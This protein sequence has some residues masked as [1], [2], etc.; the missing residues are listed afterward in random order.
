MSTQQIE[1]TYGETV[2]MQ[3]DGAQASAPIL[4]DG[5]STGYQTA[6]A[7][8]RTE[9]AVRL[10]CAKMWGPIYAT[11]EDAEAAG[12]TLGV[13]QIV[14]WDDVEYSTLDAE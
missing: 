13:D 6:D 12:R 2:V 3:W 4:V 14:I 8:H 10:V 11:A 9:E 7:R 5:D 1:I